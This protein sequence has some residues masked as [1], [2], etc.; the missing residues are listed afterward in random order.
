MHDT[1]SDHPSRRRFLYCSTLLAAACALPPL[2]RARAVPARISVREHGAHGDG[3]HDD[4]AAFRKAIAATPTGGTVV[5]PAGNY[6]LD[7][8][9]DRAVAVRLKSNMKLELQAGARLLTKPNA[10]PRHY[11]LWVDQA[12]NV[13]IYGIP[14]RDGALP[15]LVGERDRHLGQGGEWGQGVRI[16]GSSN[17]TVRNLL[18][19]DFWGDGITVGSFRKPNG[20]PR[21]FSKNVTIAGVR[22]RN[23][24]RQG[25]SI[26]GALVIQVLDSEFSDTKGTKPEDGIDIEPDKGDEVRQVTIRNCRCLNNNGNGIEINGMNGIVDGV[27]ITGCTLSGNRGTGFYGQNMRNVA[28]LDNPRIERNGFRGMH[29]SATSRNVTIRG[30]RF[31]SNATRVRKP[32]PAGK[33]AAL[34]ASG[35][36]AAIATTVRRGT[37]NAFHLSIAEGSHVEVR[38]NTF[39]R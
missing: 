27:T 35:E 21:I 18:I 16:Q 7:G 34:R 13:E 23:N 26:I 2:V 31:S 14:G 38:D 12:E 25:I 17:V 20:G 4:T 10:L 29:L 15:E 1:R 24:R 6:L 32:A 36:C 8:S 3:R 5:V 28:L 30:N 9:A 11:L 33:A 37:A 22:C 19:R 39:C